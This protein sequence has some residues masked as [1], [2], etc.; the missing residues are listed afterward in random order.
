MA[1]APPFW[2]GSSIDDRPSDNLNVRIVNVRKAHD[3]DSSAAVSTMLGPTSDFLAPPSFAMPSV[4]PPS[5]PTLHSIHAPTVGL[6]D[7]VSA[8]P[9]SVQPGG[10]WPQPGDP[11]DARVA[12]FVNQPHNAQCKPLFCR[13]N[14]GNYLFGT[15]R[16]Q[17]RV[18]Q[19]T[20]QL[21]AFDENTWI[22]MEDF[23]RRRAGSQMVHLQQAC[24][25]VSSSAAFP[26]GAM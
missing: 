20:G 18:E 5:L 25:E 1:P 22:P 15:H 23:V 7:P 12:E 3:G 21:E 11:I 6:S 16:T 17:L 9:A 4:V 24:V 10:Y 26:G 8:P 13:L 14:E 19:L 2:N